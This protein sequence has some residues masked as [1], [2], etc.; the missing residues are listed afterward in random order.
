MPQRTQPQAP[1][2]VPAAIYT[3][4]DAA[5][6]ISCEF[7]LPFQRL[8]ILCETLRMFT[9]HLYAYT[10]PCCLCHDGDDRTE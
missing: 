4:G 2:Y 3:L 5:G 7:T 9:K 8:L 6:I 1:G 10:E